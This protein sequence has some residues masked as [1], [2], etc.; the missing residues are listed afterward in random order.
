M[1]MQHAGARPHI[2]IIDPNTLAVLGLKHILQSVMPM[3]QLD[4]FGSFAEL[5]ANHPERYFHYFV[6]MRIVLA[7]MAFFDARR[8]KTIVLSPAASGTS[9]L[10]R[11][12]YIHVDQPEKQLVRDILA[13]EQYAHAEGRNL[14]QLPASAAAHSCDLSPREVEVLSLVAKGYINKQ[15]ADVL[16]ISLPT[17]VTHRKNMMDKLGIRSVSALT[18]YAV[19]HGYVGIGDI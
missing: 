17:V 16:N 7:H 2:A 19:M 15:I 10:D 6:E 11:F 5:C 12:H 18:I 1:L 13:M 3:V 4:T 9:G 8:H 14:P